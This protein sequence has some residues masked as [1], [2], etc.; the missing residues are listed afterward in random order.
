[1]TVAPIPRHSSLPV[2]KRDAVAILRQVAGLTIFAAM[3]T[4]PMQLEAAD[5]SRWVSSHIPAA[6]AGVT[7]PFAVMDLTEIKLSGARNLWDL[8]ASRLKYSGFGL[9]RPFLLGSGRLAILINGRR[10]SIRLYTSMPC[11]Y[12]LWN[13][14]RS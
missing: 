7:R 11:R 4:V 5:R 13:G 1:M 3:L 14:L 8:P 9:Y 10:I 6:G 12:R 2:C